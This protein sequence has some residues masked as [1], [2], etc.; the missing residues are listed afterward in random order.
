MG[1]NLNI[2]LKKLDILLITAVI[3]FVL[4][5]LFVKINA[6]SVQEAI[7]P[8]H[9][10]LILAHYWQGDAVKDTLKDLAEEFRKK[11]PDTFIEFRVYSYTDMQNMLLSPRPEEI[12]DKKLKE[13]ISSDIFVFDPRW[14]SEMIQNK[15]L[16]PLTNFTQEAAATPAAEWA[17]PL[18]ASI[19]LLFYNIDVLKAQGFERPPKN[20]TDFKKY[21]RELDRSPASYG[22]TFSL[23]AD[24]IDYSDIYPW[25][26]ASGTKILKKSDDETQIIP[27]FNTESV[28]KTLAF[29]SELKLERLISPNTISKTKTQKLNE[30]INNKAGMMIASVEDI[31]TVRKK[32]GDTSFGVSTIPYPDDFS[33]SRPVFGVANAYAGIKNGSA[34]KG[35]A[36]AFISFLEEHSPALANAVHALPGNGNTPVSLKNN[37]FYTKAYDIFE[38][39]ELVQEFTGVPGVRRLDAAVRSALAALFEKFEKFE[40]EQGAIENGLNEKEKARIIQKRAEEKARI[41]QEYTEDTA[42][43]IQERWEEILGTAREPLIN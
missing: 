14:L 34:R 8:A 22:F 3:I 40:K 25:I 30:F 43:N 2:K 19:D 12:T 28:V 24:G 27:N 26:W 32:M 15:V 5:T 1:T 7:L 41:I 35:E 37:P 6:G 4:I 42:R 31:D 11:N 33:G 18:T 9:N 16:E 23:G 21:A 38:G 10:S 36:W 39:S 20:W 29:I 13:F 17:V